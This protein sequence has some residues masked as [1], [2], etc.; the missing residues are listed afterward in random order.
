L[1]EKTG[2]SLASEFS[3]LLPGIGTD[4]GAGFQWTGIASQRWEEGALHLNI[5]A[6]LT[7]EQK[8]AAFA[9]MIL[10]GPDGWTVRPV[11]EFVYQRNFG[12]D[13][14]WGVLAGAIWKLGEHMALDLALRHGETARRFD[15]QVRAGITFDL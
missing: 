9:G 8:A 4:D 15:Y 13:E 2:P 5:G 7:R 10:E 14:E 11:A 1:Q 3:I 12:V 6:A